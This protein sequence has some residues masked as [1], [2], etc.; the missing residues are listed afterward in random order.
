MVHFPPFS[1]ASLSD[2]DCT[3]DFARE[4]SRGDR[5]AVIAT[6]P[7]DPWIGYVWE[8]EED[9]N[10]ADKRAMGRKRGKGRRKRRFLRIE[11]I[12]P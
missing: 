5:V 4:K 1:T 11:W 3:I 8:V 12:G 10:D 2:V 6:A 9:N 7:L